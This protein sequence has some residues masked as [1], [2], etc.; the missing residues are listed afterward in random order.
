MINFLCDGLMT[1][2]RQFVVPR[3]L[4]SHEKADD[5]EESEL[6]EEEETAEGRPPKDAFCENPAVVRE[7]RERQRAERLQQ[8]GGGSGKG[9]GSASSSSSDKKFDVVGKTNFFMIYMVKCSCSDFHLW[10]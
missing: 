3:V 5:S 10:Y 1:F 4:R 8:R 6:D 2:R 9:R 7:R